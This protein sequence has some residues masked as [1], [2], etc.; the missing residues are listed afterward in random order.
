[1][2]CNFFCPG[3][4]NSLTGFTPGKWRAWFF[5][6]HSWLFSGP[7][8]IL[9][10]KKPSRATKYVSNN[11][12]STGFTRLRA[13]GNR[14]WD[15]KH[16]GS[17]PSGASFEQPNFFVNWAIKSFFSQIDV[18]FHA[19]QSCIFRLFE[20]YCILDQSIDNWLKIDEND[21]FSPE[22]R[23]HDPSKAKIRPKS[24][25]KLLQHYC[26]DFLVQNMAT[27]HPHPS[28]Q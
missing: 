7:R 1:M 11:N 26:R 13:Q 6:L 9:P 17:G 8:R 2:F 20:R 15:D 3:K 18:K 22:S 21:G 27:N 28:P 19:A 10:V 23:Y 4:V 24:K 5:L 16:T 12:F 14:N 25:W